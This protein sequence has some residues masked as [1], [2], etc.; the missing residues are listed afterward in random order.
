MNP[1]HDSSDAEGEADPEYAVGGGVLDPSLGLSFHIPQQQSSAPQQQFPSYYSPNQGYSP[2]YAPQ[3]YYQPYSDYQSDAGPSTYNAD[4]NHNNPYLEDEP[5]INNNPYLES[6]P[7]EAYQSIPEPGVDEAEAEKD[8]LRLSPRRGAPRAAATAK[9]SAPPRPTSSPAPIPR[10]TPTP[11]PVPKAATPA[12]SAITTAA[13]PK[14]KPQPR[15]RSSGTPLSV[16]KRKKDAKSPVAAEAT[17]STAVEPGANGAAKPSAVV[18]DEFCSFCQG[19][20]AKNKG[21]FPEKMLTCEKCGRSGHPSC[22][23]MTSPNLRAEVKKYAWQCIECKVCEICQ[24]KGDDNRLMF[25]DG[26]DRGWHSYC[27]DPPLSKPPRGIWKCPLCLGQ[28]VPKP[29]DTAA[30]MK[31]DKSKNDKEKERGEAKADALEEVPKGKKAARRE[32]SGTPSGSV[33]GRRSRGKVRAEEPATIPV[34]TPREKPVEKL[35]ETIAKDNTTRSKRPRIDKLRLIPPVIAGSTPTE[36]VTPQPEPSKAAP[37]LISR[38]STIIK[39][40]LPQALLK[41]RDR[42]KRKVA[43][44]EEE[45]EEAEEEEEELPFGGIIR[46]EDADTTR[47]AVQEED[48]LAFELSRKRAEALLGPKRV[49]TPTVERLDSPALE[50]TGGRA[51]RERVL[52]STVPPN[53]LRT[54][55][56]VS[57]TCGGTAEKIKAI[58]IGPYDIDTWY[59]A[60]YPEEYSRVPEG[61]LWLCQFC[62]KYMKSGFVC[63]RHQARHPPGDEIYRDGNISV[64]EVDGRKNKIY[65]QNLCLL[66]K[67]FL[68]HKTLYYDVEPFLFY[69]MTENHHDGAKFVGYFSKEKRSPNLNVSCIMTLPVRQRKGWGNLLIDFSYLLSKKEGRTGTPEKPLSALGALSYRNYWTLSVFKY[70]D[71]CDHAP[72]LD[73]IS[74]ATSMI[75]EDVLATLQHHGMIHIDE[76]PGALEAKSDQAGDSPTINDRGLARKA[77]THATD[78]SL[79]NTNIPEHYEILWDRQ[80]V[81]AHLDRYA[82][83]GYLELQ[84]EHLKY[85]PFLITRITLGKDGM[86]HTLAM[87]KGQAVEVQGKE[88]D[89][90]SAS[91]DPTTADLEPSTG[92]PSAGI[93]MEGVS[94]EGVPRED[95]S[96]QSVPVERVSKDGGQDEKA[97]EE[98]GS[99][100]MDVDDPPTSE[101]QPKSETPVS[102]V[103]SPLRA[104]NISSST[105]RKQQRTPRTPSKATPRAR[106]SAQ[107]E[108]ETTSMLSPLRSSRKSGTPR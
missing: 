68:D 37:A 75:S 78:K 18:R 48:K 98:A 39:I 53:M 35:V 40:K 27:L 50:T 8:P 99:T 55:S 31:T 106:R 82:A 44:V 101:F 93:S 3:P 102:D 70:L 4:G 95:G 96:V 71:T 43:P 16:P 65:C 88:P 51:L 15:A 107:R 69:V 67:M 32:A 9:S 89:L 7:P 105:P 80:A 1:Y 100:A 72:T 25:C 76:D 2:Y 13:R 81:R 61:R 108:T 73:E 28:P 63:G 38:P 19:T 90:V 10:S 17:S 87:A 20:D 6:P 46:G 36:G 47:T 14:P 77:L 21:G 64:F 57:V 24:S 86:L 22:L 12:T 84:P 52:M 49:A 34:E 60:P 85:T 74:K 103:K 41:N 30:R 5:I 11:A 104:T 97:D 56:T 58:R 23:S 54:E 29:P 91:L 33:A 42:K 26:C 83:K 62:L 92:V 59:S 66:A 79:Q 45:E 94:A